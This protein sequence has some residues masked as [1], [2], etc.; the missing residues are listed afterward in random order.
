MFSEE[1]W[2]ESQGVRF[3]IISESYIIIIKEETY[4]Q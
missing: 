3:G 2:N 4:L 1:K